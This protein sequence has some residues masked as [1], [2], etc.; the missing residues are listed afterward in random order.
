LLAML[1]YAMDGNDVGVSPAPLPLLSTAT[2]PGLLQFLQN[3]LPGLVRT[4]TAIRQADELLGLVT[5]GAWDDE[6]VVYRGIEG[7]GTAQPYTDGG[8]ITLASWNPEFI[9]RT[10]V[11]F[12]MGFQ[13]APLEESRSAR[14]QIS[15]ADEKRIM[16]GEALE[17]QRNRVA[18]YGYND[19]SGRTYGFLNDPNLPAYVTVANGAAASPL[20]SKKTTLEIIADLLQGLTALQVQSLGRI[21]SKKTPILIVIPNGYENYLGTPTQFGYSVFKWMED[22]YPNVRFE[23]APELNDANGGVSAIYYYAETVVDSGTDDQRTFIQVCPTKM[24][25]LGVEK[26][27]KGYVEGFSNATAGAICKRP[28]AVYRQTGA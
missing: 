17:V 21:K 11:R 6:Q 16:C 1:Q 19:G 8:N 24:Y 4:I 7:T 9:Q 3:W 22:N 13:V 18:M 5:A 14:V 15:S 28:Y 2:I 26:K 10:V 25:T 23:S 27:V 12:E 20:W